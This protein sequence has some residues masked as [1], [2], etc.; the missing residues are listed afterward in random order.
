MKPR[1]SRSDCNEA[2]V[3]QNQ[4]HKSQSIQYQNQQTTALWIYQ[5]IIIQHL[6]FITGPKR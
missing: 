3:T 6:L 1:P 5:M 2:P 4:Y